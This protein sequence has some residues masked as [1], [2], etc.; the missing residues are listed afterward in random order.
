MNP[1]YPHRTSDRAIL[2]MRKALG[3][4][5]F[6]REAMGVWDEF[7]VH[8]PVVKA[9]RWAELVDVGPDVTIKPDAVAVDMSHA[10]DISIAAA[11]CEGESTHL[12]EVWSG[13]DTAAAVEW[14]TER[15]G[16]RIP[17]V[18]DSVGPAASLVPELRARKC[19]V[20]Q[21]N[22]ADMARACGLFENAVTGDALTHGGQ[23]TLTDALA[24][25]RKRPIRDAGGWG[26][27]RRDPNSLI[28]PLVAATLALLGATENKRTAK[29]GSGATFA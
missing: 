21:T 14:I 11:W 23:P 7:T 27:D 29:T 15:V 9:A 8:Q 3:D 10:R 18:V 1:S 20:R 22:G 6:R 4:D 17:V 19:K 5:S 13:V 28:H 25:A 26:W 24:G 12:E 16:R 2:R